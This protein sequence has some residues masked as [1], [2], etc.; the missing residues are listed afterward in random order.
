MLLAQAGLVVAI[1]G[2]CAIARLLR[3][4]VGV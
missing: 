3:G 1:A 4:V 2:R